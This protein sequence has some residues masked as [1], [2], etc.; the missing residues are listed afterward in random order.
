M[1][2]GDIINNPEVMSIESINEEKRTAIITWVD[3]ESGLHCHCE[4]PLDALKK[5][6]IH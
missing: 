1:K 6:T 3:E 2:E 5:I 4:V